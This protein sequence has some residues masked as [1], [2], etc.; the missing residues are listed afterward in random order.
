MREYLPANTNQ[1]QTQQVTGNVPARALTRPAVAPFSAPV[2][3]R[4]YNKVNV[5]AGNNQWS[6]DKIT[7]TWAIS[8]SL[9]LTFGQLKIPPHPVHS[10][11]VKQGAG[12]QELHM[13]LTWI[14]VDNKI[15]ETDVLKKYTPGKSHTEVLAAQDMFN[16]AKEYYKSKEA[17]PNQKMNG[18]IIEIKQTLS[19]C[20]SCLTFLHK[21]LNEITIKTI[22]RASS[23]KMHNSNLGMEI[24][25]FD[26]KKPENQGVSD[27]NDIHGLHLKK[28]GMEWG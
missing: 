10:L 21:L 12:D 24:N 26:L 3:Q 17:D 28:P 13:A 5:E 19:P 18:L 7:S 4:N 20:N 25:K 27:M 2:V 6:K 15:Y 11:S 16:T 23:V 14:G 8:D 22:V 1:H 9:N